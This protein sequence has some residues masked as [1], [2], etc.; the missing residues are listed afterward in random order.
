VVARGPVDLG[1]T[2]AADPWVRLLAAVIDGLAAV[3]CLGPGL[4][5]LRRELLQMAR[6]GA[7][8]VTTAM[9]TGLVVLAA[10]SMVLVVVQISLLVMRGQT[11]GKSLC[12]VRIVRVGTGEL[13]GFLRAV[14]LRS[15]VPGFLG[16]VPCLGPVFSLANILFILRP[17]RRCL[18]D[19]LA[20]T[21]VVWARVRTLEERM[22]L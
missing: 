16:A 21:V 10:G 9:G 5:M 20:G 12:N 14:V 11:I 1:R 6:N 19:H 7:V 22:G 13:P 3:M 4:A 2:A 8:E 15:W 17:D 18:H